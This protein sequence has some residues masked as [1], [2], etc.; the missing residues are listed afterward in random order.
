MAA[1]CSCSNRLE[2]EALRGW[3]D[4]R[5]DANAAACAAGPLRVGSGNAST[6]EMG[7]ARSGNIRLADGKVWK[8]AGFGVIRP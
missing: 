6:K 3:R 2:L 4:T 5:R 7:S 8:G 1:S